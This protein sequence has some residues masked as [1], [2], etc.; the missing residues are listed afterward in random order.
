MGAEYD[1]NK[2]PK[3]K[4]GRWIK[5]NNPNKPSSLP[6]KNALESNQNELTEAEAS[7]YE[8]L[9]NANSPDTYGKMSAYLVNGNELIMAN[10]LDVG[11]FE[12]TIYGLERSYG[13]MSKKNRE[14]LYN[15][16]VSVL[17]S[18]DYID[19]HDVFGEDGDV[20][21]A[22]DD[23]FT[24]GAYSIVC[25]SSYGEDAEEDV[26]GIIIR[27]GGWEEYV[28]HVEAA[29]YPPEEGESLE[30]SEEELQWFKEKLS[31]VADAETAEISMDRKPP[32]N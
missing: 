16:F 2:H 22:Y 17:D 25:G 21:L 3:G 6:D 12:E 14:E 28:D 31:S 9:E 4:D 30:F 19:I 5:T 7:L 13:K 24:F 15:H 23:D 26:D 27:S 11:D 10:H 18:N 1:P 29:D 32:R 20:V 8:T